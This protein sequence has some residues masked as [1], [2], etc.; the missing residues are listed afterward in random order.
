MVTL[1]ISIAGNIVTSVTGGT[2]TG[3]KLGKAT[4]GN[5]FKKIMKGTGGGLGT[6]LASLIGGV[7]CFRLGHPIMVLLDSIL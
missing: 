2:I 4:Q 3:V 1:S 6:G 5:T 7:I